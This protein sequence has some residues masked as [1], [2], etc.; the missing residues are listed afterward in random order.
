MKTAKNKDARLEIRLTKEDLD[1]LKIASF[2]I[3]Q[4]P[5]K[6]VRMFIDTTINSLKLQVQRGEIKLEDFETILND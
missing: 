1:L 4:T 2:T 5:S 6:L 3:G